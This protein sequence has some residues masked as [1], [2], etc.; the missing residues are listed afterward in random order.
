MHDYFL[1]TH[2]IKIRDFILKN[3]RCN[4]FAGCGMGKTFSTLSALEQIK[5]R[6]ILV[7]APLRVAMNEWDSQAEKFDINLTFSKIIGT[8]KERT[9][10][11]NAI[12]DVYLINY[13]NL[14][15]LDKNFHFKFK[16]VVCDEATKIKHHSCYRIRDNI[17]G[18]LGS[19]ATALVKHCGKVS[20]WI[21][22]TATPAHN[23]LKDYWG[24]QFPVDFG[25]CL[26]FCRSQ[27]LMSY[28]LV[29]EYGNSMKRSYFPLPGTKE[30]IEKK[31]AP[32]SLIV[33]NKEY[34]ND[35]IEEDVI[36]KLPE[37]LLKIY[38]RFHNQN[39][40][41]LTNG[42]IIL[43]RTG[44]KKRQMASGFILDDNGESFAIHDIKLK[45]LK[46]LLE[47]LDGNIIIVY[48]FLAEVELLKKLLPEAK[49]LNEDTKV[50]LKEWNEGKL[51]YLLIHPLSAGHGIN[52]QHGG[53]KM[54]FYSMDYNG[55]LYTQ[56][57]ER[58]GSFR[59]KLSGY[60]R[61]TYIYRLIVSGTVEEKIKRTVQ[62]K[63]KN[64]L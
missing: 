58:I 12:A 25:A 14:K 40:Y 39:A 6:P 54:V 62:E 64:A 63:L 28:F 20:R 4:I 37:N 7:V 35:I 32:Y 9:A 23:H 16:T 27:F 50:T 15:W 56:T 61:K 43:D 24:L 10:A 33:K 18:R 41:K 55:E 19:N 2:Q 45:K 5:E 36:V 17:R 29:R 11:Y 21:N 13:E 52:L 46:E 34:C 42:N 30:N 31:I 59:Q 1:K 26:G 3:K 44:I 51:K 38:K 49:I 57:I 60:D 47:K 53:N 8:E 48:Q 22:L